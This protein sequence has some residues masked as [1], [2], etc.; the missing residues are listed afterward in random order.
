MTERDLPGVCRGR[1]DTDPAG[2]GTGR[3]PG[4]GD[5]PSTIDVAK[6]DLVNAQ[7]ADEMARALAPTPGQVE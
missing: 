2:G 7:W 6:L 3:L 5:R 4:A 1:L